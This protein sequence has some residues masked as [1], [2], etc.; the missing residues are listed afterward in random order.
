MRQAGDILEIINPLVAAY[1]ANKEKGL[2]HF[3]IVH[4]QTIGIMGATKFYFHN[5]KGKI[6]RRPNRNSNK[7]ERYDRF[8]S[9]HT[10]SAWSAAAYS[11]IF[12][13]E[14]KY[15]AIPLYA[16]AALTGFSRVKSKQHT[17]NQVL[18]AIVLAEGMNFINSKMQWSNEYKYS[19]V[20]LDGD[21]R[22]ILGFNFRF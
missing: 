9:G 15:V 14:N 2:G 8:P 10:S 3:A 7:R 11:R 4:G 18:A 12:L 6:G 21:G 19:Y 20:R 5:K 1:F 16:T 22:F 17:R 13:E